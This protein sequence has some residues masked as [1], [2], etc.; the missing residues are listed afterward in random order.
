MGAGGGFVVHS[1]KQDLQPKKDVDQLAIRDGKLRCERCGLPLIDGT[2]AGMLKALKMVCGRCGL[3]NDIGIKFTPAQRKD[4]DARQMQLCEKDVR[5]IQIAYFAGR[6]KK[7][8]A[9]KDRL[10]STSAVQLLD[11]E[12]AAINAKV[13]NTEKN[14]AYIREMQEKERK[15]AKNR[16][17]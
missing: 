15:N 10:R 8:E 4:Y 5:D 17:H 16:N 12:L 1:L 7:E 3:E 11:E 14:L 9:E 2:F 13:E 6:L